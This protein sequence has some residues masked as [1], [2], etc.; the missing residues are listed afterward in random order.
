MTTTDATT[1]PWGPPPF[2]E[3]PERG[4]VDVVAGRTVVWAPGTVLRAGRVVLG[5]SPFSVTV[6]PEE[7]RDFATR[8]CDAEEH[9]AEAADDTERAAARFL[10]DLGIVHPK[11]VAY[12]EVTD[13]EVVI[14]MYGDPTLLD[15]LLASLAVEGHPV[16]VVDDA[17]P[18]P[19]HAS[20]I[21]AIAD[22]YGARLIRHDVNQGPGGARNTGFAATSAPFIAFIDS[23]ARASDDWIA[24]LRPMLDDEQ[25]GAVGPRVRP[26]FDGDSAIE[27]YEDTRS[28]IDMGPVPSRVVH[29]VMVGWLPSA[30]VLVRRSAVTDP[31]FEPGLRIGE[32][33]DLFWRMDEAGWNVLYAP[34]VQVFHEVRTT[35]RAFMGR[36]AGYGSSAALLEQRHP[37]RLTPASPSLSG[38]AVI[39]LASTGHRWLAAGVAGYELARQRASL[40]DEVPLSVVAE[41]AGRQIWSDGFWT[42]HL[43]RR[44]WWPVGWAVLA[45]TPRSGLA[46]GVAA[47]MMWEPVRDHILRPTRL[48]PVKSLAMRLLD[49]AS[50]GTGVITNAIRERV[51]N[52]VTPRPRIPWW[53]RG[54]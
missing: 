39:G 49:D 30:A 53:P 51:P 34:D 37:L 19:E 54:R 13:V 28:E 25:L 44:D 1:T 9:G 7:F 26:R 29:G 20:R 27:L 21:A 8:V 23:D 10:L 5:G 31:P 42:G 35:W 17:T 11:P 47:A 48:G 50:Y 45:S 32:D 15:P 4:E 41:M 38:L 18:D 52:V 3:P 24:R 14:P 16:T 40:P 6:V 43:L 22:H 36:R 12:G 46:R 2:P 33:V